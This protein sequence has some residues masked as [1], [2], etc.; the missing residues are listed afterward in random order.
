MKIITS[1]VL[2]FFVAILL[3]CDLN[4]STPITET[5]NI[6]AFH[7]GN[8]IETRFEVPSG[9][10]RKQVDTSSFGHWLRQLP[11][12][13]KGAQVKLYNG[14]LKGNQDAHLA[15]VDL[16]IGSKDLHQCAD[17]V[18]RL[19]ADY[20]FSKKKYDVIH[21]HFTNGFDAL[22]SKWRKGQRIQVSGNNV[23]W[24]GGGKTGDS[25]SSYWQYLE[26][27]FS[28]AGTLSLSKELKPKKIEDIEIGDVFIQGGSPGHAVIVVEL[29]INSKT[30]EKIFMLAQ[31][32]MP[33]QEIQ[34]LRNPSS[35]ENSPWFEIQGSTLET[36]EWDFQFNH[37]KSFN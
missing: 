26:K 14:S 17:A 22:Y 6:Q 9:F 33:A 29:A 7:T 36:P 25:Q 20:L 23:Q 16:S 37:L 30:G 34:V 24:V 5:N 13:E 35:Y 4:S 18:M 21:F 10:E 32:Y 27:V 12:K 2:L 31:S 15:V 28:Y 11:L 8:T 1:I 19:R 3:A